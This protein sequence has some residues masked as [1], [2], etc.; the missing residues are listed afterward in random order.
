MNSRSHTGRRLEARLED[1]HTDGTQE[2]CSRR[3]PTPPS[4]GTVL[5]LD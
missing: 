1:H 3:N 2:A 5:E 4:K